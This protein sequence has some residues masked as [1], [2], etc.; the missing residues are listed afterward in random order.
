MRDTSNWSVSFNCFM[1]FRAGLAAPWIFFKGAPRGIKQ[2]MYCPFWNGCHMDLFTGSFARSVTKYDFVKDRITISQCFFNLN[3]SEYSIEGG[4]ADYN[5]KTWIAISIW[6]T[7]WF[8]L[9]L[10]DVDHFEIECSTI[11]SLV[12]PGFSDLI[13]M[14]EPIELS[15]LFE[16]VRGL[17]NSGI[18]SSVGE[19]FSVCWLLATTGV[20]SSLDALKPR[21]WCKM[22]F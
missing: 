7:M 2:E 14:L 16:M 3:F 13:E 12:M 21:R 22:Y 10:K 20:F 19:D 9:G 15:E 1:I 18:V 6:H 11:Y 5:R 8:C 17:L 4:M